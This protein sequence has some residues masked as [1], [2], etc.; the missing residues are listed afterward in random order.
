MC[1][2][3][4]VHVD[5]DTH[6][7][8]TFA[9]NI[10]QG[11]CTPHPRFVRL[12]GSSVADIPVPDD[13]NPRTSWSPS[14]PTGYSVLIPFL[15]KQGRTVDR[16]LGD[17]NCLFRALSLQL[18]GVQD[19]HMDLRRMIA[20]C[21]S[22]IKVFQGIHA[23]INKTRFA[24][25]VQK[26]GKTCIWGTNL[27]IIVTATLFG[28]D[29]YVASDSYRP[30]KPVWL[31]YSPNALATTELRKSSVNDLSSRLPVLHRKQ[32][33][34]LELTHVS[35]CHFDAIKPVSG[36]QLSR[37]VLEAPNTT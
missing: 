31:K 2:Y 4:H 22:K 34:W 24:D 29:I 37:P 6:I 23:T 14:P 26:I 20:Q 30:G 33:Q 21:E 9:M 32:N 35:R 10:L 27:E 28:V 8:A 11:I 25:H 13:M 3:V 5:T 36:I 15:Q 7:T 17:G 12:P 1:V 18:T 16:V 19:H